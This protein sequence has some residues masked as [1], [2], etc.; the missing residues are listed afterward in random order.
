M[1]DPMTPTAPPPQGQMTMN[2][3]WP[4]WALPALLVVASGLAGYGGNEITRSD[5]NPARLAV[6][7]ENVSRKVST[8]EAQLTTITGLAADVRQLTTGQTK[9]ETQFEQLRVNVE[10]AGR[11]RWSRSD[12]EN[13]VQNDI[14]PLRRALQEHEQ[15]EEHVTSRRTLEGFEVRIRNLETRAGGR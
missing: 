11:D 1:P 4:S 3:S 5:E 7:V 14:Y 10:L 12:H 2:T 6:Q 8:V 15:L 13:F 9:M